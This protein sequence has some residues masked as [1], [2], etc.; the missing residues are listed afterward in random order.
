MNPLFDGCHRE[1]CFSFSGLE[2]QRVVV[3][4]LPVSSLVFYAYRAG[5]VG[6]RVCPCILSCF[7]MFYFGQS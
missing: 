3:G 4:F 6:C 5:G 1:F 7:V 2:K